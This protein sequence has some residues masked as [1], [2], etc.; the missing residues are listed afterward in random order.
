MDDQQT[1]EQLEPEILEALARQLFRSENPPDVLWDTALFERMGRSTE[2][3]KVVDH[4]TRESYRA[5]TRQALADA[6]QNA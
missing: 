6:A 3:M 5:R 2:G 4:K 1:G